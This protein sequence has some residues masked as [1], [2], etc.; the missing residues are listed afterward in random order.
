MPEGG[1]RRPPGG[2][3]ADLFEVAADRVL[4]ERAPLA[5]RLRPTTFDDVVGQR[6]L[7]GP[8]APLRRLAEADRL[9]SV[10][11]WGPPGTG[12]T[13]LA[14]LV[15]GSTAKAFVR[16]SAVEAGVADVRRVLGD[17]RDRLGQHQRGTIVF[18]DEV[19]RFSRTQ[20]DALLPAVESGLI[21]LVA[22]TTANPAFAVTAPLLS[23]STV[24]E[25]MP[26]TAEDVEEVVRRGLEA[27]GA[28][29]HPDAVAAIVAL[30]DGDARSALGTV[31]IAVA[32]A[33]GEPV[34]VEHVTQARHA[35]LLHHGRDAH[36]D[37]LSALIKS[38]R[39]SDPDAAVYWLARLLD[40]GEDPRLLARRLVISAA[41]DIGLADPQALVVAQSAAAALEHVGLPEGALVLAEACVYLACAPKSNRVTVALGRAR[42]DVHHGPPAEVPPALRDQHG[43]PVAGRRPV[44]YRSPH[45]DPSGAAAQPHRPP[46]LDGRVYYEPSEQGVE[47][48]V[49]AGRRPPGDRW[50][51]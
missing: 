17:A 43:P 35:R 38:V 1:A 6:H 9:R 36:Y 42:H 41:E 47:T 5:Q 26:L 28:T 16:L 50:A 14:E 25:L 4:A 30:A 48:Q 13:T 44:A 46:G 31:E 3:A 10:V 7:V 22:A 11:L 49:A 20:Q 34:A 2:P 51:R 32:L 37:Q 29:A 27:E 19:H 21:V 24:W 45:D 33:G 15:A 39:G 23:R 18:I 40:G 8:G 12:K